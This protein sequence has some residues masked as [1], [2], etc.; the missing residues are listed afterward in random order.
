VSVAFLALGKYYYDRYLQEMIDGEIKAYRSRNF[1]LAGYEIGRDL[2]SLDGYQRCTYSNCV[3]QTKRKAS[4]ATNR[5]PVAYGYHKTVA[6]DRDEVIDGMKGF[7]KLHIDAME[8][9]EKGETRNRIFRICL[10]ANGYRDE[11]RIDAMNNFASILEKTFGRRRFGSRLGKITE[12]EHPNGKFMNLCASMN[13]E[14]GRTLCVRSN[15]PG[16][17][18]VELFDCFVSK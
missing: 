11:M 9:T 12:Y 17:I 14:D 10:T 8:Y 18:S 3:S 5:A 13:L 2:D 6:L 16:Q 15:D 7:S 4:T 1:A